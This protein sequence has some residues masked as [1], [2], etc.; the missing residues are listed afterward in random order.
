MATFTAS[1]LQVGV[2][3]V[4]TG[5]NVVGCRFATTVTMTAAS[6][7]KLVR[8]PNG[9]TIVDWMFYGDDAAAN[10]TVKIGTSNTPSGIAA[11]FSLSQSASAEASPSSFRAVMGTLLPV[12]ISLSDDVMPKEVWIQMIISIAASESADYRFTLFYTM[13]DLTGINTIR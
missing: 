1:A 2:K 3:A 11:A 4:H 8:V 12:R 6:I 5:V 10:Q 9:A 7:V 13:D